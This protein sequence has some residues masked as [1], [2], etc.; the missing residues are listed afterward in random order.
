PAPQAFPAI[1]M[2]GTTRD[3]D[4]GAKASPHRG[5]LP[6]P[7]EYAAHSPPML[8]SPGCVS[9]AA[10]FVAMPRGCVPRTTSKRSHQRQNLEIRPRTW[11]TGG[12][13]EGPSI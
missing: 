12:E 2:G 6:N 7:P 11:C 1:T 8:E 5:E 10:F 4:A 13:L 3:V 9:D